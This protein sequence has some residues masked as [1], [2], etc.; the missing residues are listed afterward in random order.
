MDD[1]K[2]LY[3]RSVATALTEALADTPV[4]CLLG[5]RQCGKTTLVRMLDPNRT[6]VT[7]DNDSYLKTAKTDPLGFVG[8]LPDS[9]ILDEIQH[10]PELL[11]AIK[12]TVDRNRRA[13]RFL[14]T[15]SANLL[16]LPKVA[17]SLAGRM[18][19][20]YLQPLTDSE[21]E[22]SSG[23]F[24]KEFLAGR[25]ATEIRNEDESS[26]TTIPCRLVAGGY[27][28]PL[29]RPNARARQWHRQYLKSIIERDIKD[30]A[31]IKDGNDLLRLLEL[32]ALRTGGLL[33]ATGLAQDLGLHRTTVEHYIAVLEKLFLIRRLPAWHNNAARRLIKTPKIHM[34]DSGLSATLSDLTEK[35]WIDHRDQMGRLLESYVVQQIITQASWTGADLRFWHYRDKDKVEVDLVITQGRKVWGIEVKASRS[36][37]TQD[38]R[39]LSRLAA[40]CGQNFQRGII[41]YGGTSA[42]PVA[43]SFLA[44]PITKLWQ[45]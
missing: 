24:L 35:D 17:E 19:T 22:E 7:F 29:T 27:P 21:K 26:A 43:S 1:Q 36:V 23:K 8:S 32:L 42:L 41:L 33:N 38:G 28:E 11:P 34:V 6:Y 37:A 44:V 25:I 15:G 14:L 16:L 40:Q 9:V 13:G 45:L 30:V 20:V 10:V 18:E 2:N 39:G 31:R 3:T 5:P 4:V 12:H